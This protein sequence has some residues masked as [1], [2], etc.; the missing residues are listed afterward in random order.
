MPKVP[1]S[2]ALGI[3]EAQNGPVRAREAKTCFSFPRWGKNG[4]SSSFSQNPKQVEVA[5]DFWYDSTEISHHQ[6]HRFLHNCD[7]CDIGSIAVRAVMGI[8]HP[9][10]FLSFITR[11]IHTCLVAARVRLWTRCLCF[12]FSSIIGAIQT[13][14]VAARARLKDP[15]LP[16]I[17]FFFL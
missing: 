14:L 8:W 7:Q 6:Y 5:L 15:S 2:D 17:F 16:C 10:F 1:S 13:C 3:L 4:A 11:V 12:F 9:R